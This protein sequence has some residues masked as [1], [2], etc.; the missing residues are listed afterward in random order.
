MSDLSFTITSYK[1]AQFVAK[2][3]QKNRPS[4]EG[5]DVDTLEQLEPSILDGDIS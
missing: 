4:I 2:Y 3:L 1:L 5:K